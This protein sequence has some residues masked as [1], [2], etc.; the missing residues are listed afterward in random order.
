MDSTYW[1]VADPLK[2]TS[3]NEARLEFLARVTYADLRFGSAEFRTRGWETDRGVVYIRYGPPPVIATFSPETAELDDAERI[4]RVTY[5][6][7]YPETKL[8]FVFIG[9][10]AMNYAFFA[11]DFRSYTENARHVAPVRWDNMTKSGRVDSI[12]VQVA[13]FRADSGIATELS[14]FADIPVGRMLQDV[15]ISQVA[16]ETGLF[17]T[18]SRRRDVTSRRDTIITRAAKSRPE[19][20]RVWR[21]VLKPGDYV[22]RVESREQASGRSARALAMVDIADFPSN[23][24]ALSDVLVAER[25]EPRNPALPPRGIG[26]YLIVP[27]AAMKFGPRDTV[28]LYWEVYGATGDTT[29]VGRLEVSLSLTVSAL[30]RGRAIEARILGGIAD[31][32]GLSAKGDERVALRY[33]RTVAIL[34]GNRIPN[35]LAVDIGEAPYGTYTLELTVRDLVSGATAT[36]QRILTLP[37]P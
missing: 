8:R 26:D 16:L 24:F 37:R 6:W 12:P 35:H 17:V 21:Q 10:P 1:N 5:V 4:G 23:R 25:I 29:G 7:Y 2:L 28:Y 22:Y 32:T 18:D 34:P 36:T 19:M 11:G 3:V 15:E 20:P 31:V 33:D 14:V 27:N 9:P 13:R 30:D